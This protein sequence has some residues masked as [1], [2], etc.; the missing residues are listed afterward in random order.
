MWNPS[1][2]WRAWSALDRLQEDLEE[3][4]APEE[5]LAG[6]SYDRLPTRLDPIDV[7]RDELGELEVDRLL[8]SGFDRPWCGLQE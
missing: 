8:A 3:L 7:L 6:V 5:G 2:G 4:K 1:I